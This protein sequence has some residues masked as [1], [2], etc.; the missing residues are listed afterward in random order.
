MT[1]LVAAVAQSSWVVDAVFDG[2]V[3]S[4]ILPTARLIPRSVPAVPCASTRIRF[5]GSTA[6]IELDKE[7]SPGASYELVLESVLD[8]GGTPLLEPDLRASLT[9]FR[10]RQ[11]SGR[12]FDLWSMLPRTNRQSDL[13]GDLR[14]F[15][16]CFQDVVDLLLADIDRFPSIFDP[17]RCPE[18]YLDLILWDRGNPFSFPMATDQKRRLAAL[19]GDMYEWKGTDAGIENTIRFFI[20][21]QATVVPYG[22]E[23]LILG[24]S[25]L[26]VDWILGAS[27]DFA[28][29]AFDI[30]MARVLTDDERAKIRS[31]VRFLK[32]APT[33]FVRL[34]EP[35]PP[36][37][38]DHWE[39][40]VSLLGDSTLLH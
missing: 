16:D 27:S 12:R 19:L 35:Q 5:D 26:G 36:A 6:S 29:Y 10:P 20:G 33:H 22:D 24:E 7:M 4:G 9:G 25:E 14:R 37:S 31:I 8:T 17:E 2:E 15:M 18:A 21:T 3:T 28:R 1:A 39:L 38:F 23:A 11:P 32:P 13:T 34:I 30:E 40:G